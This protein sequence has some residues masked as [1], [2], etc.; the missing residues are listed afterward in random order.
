MKNFNEISR[1]IAG[2]FKRIFYQYFWFI[3]LALIL[4][5][6]FLINFGHGRFYAFTD[7]SNIELH[8][9]QE[10]LKRFSMWQQTRGF[11]VELGTEAGYAV[12]LLFFSFLSAIGFSALQINFTVNLLLFILPGLSVGVLAYSIFYKDSK[13]NLIAFFAGLLTATSF[14]TYLGSAFYPLFL[15]V[16]PWITSALIT[17]TM[18]FILKTGKKRFWLV[19]I[20]LFYL[21]LASFIGLPFAVVPMAFG[22]LY[23]VY[24]ILVESKNKRQDLVKT[25]LASLL[26]LLISLPLIWANVYVVFFD[27]FQAAAISRVC[28]TDF[29]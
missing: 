11:G 17:A 13:R 29:E 22:C 7:I 10:F 23:L 28:F 25:L 1:E 12:P 20:V 21:N 27:A 3:L 26:F 5:F 8:P 16:W 24:Y 6:F 4:V 19:L 2:H 15:E 18:L 14:A 9:W